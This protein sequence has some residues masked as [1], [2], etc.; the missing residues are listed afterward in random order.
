[1]EKEEEYSKSKGTGSTGF[2]AVCGPLR[3]AATGEKA[4]E[5]PGHEGQTM[6]AKKDKG[7]S[8]KSGY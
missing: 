3:K 6:A 4:G 8:K 7:S 1:M 5:Y 2:K